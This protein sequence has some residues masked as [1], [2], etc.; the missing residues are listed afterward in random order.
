MATVMITMINI[1]IMRLD[2]WWKQSEE[3]CDY[4]YRKLAYL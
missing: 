2:A 3:N 4:G 1:I